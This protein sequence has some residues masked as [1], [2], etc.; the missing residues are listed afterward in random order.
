MTTLHVD[1][2]TMATARFAVSPLAETVAALSLL[3][4]RRLGPTAASWTARH[5]AAAEEVG[6]DEAGRAL[7]ELLARTSWFPDFLTPLALGRSATFAA[8]LAAV[9]RTP[10]EKARDDLATSLGGPMPA[11]LAAPDLVPRVTRILERVWTACVKSD[12]PRHRAVLERDIIHRAGLLVTAG[13]AQALTGLGPEVRWLGAGRIKVNA[14]EGAE[15]H[16]GRAQLIFVPC[17]LGAGWLGLRPPEAYVVVYPARGVGSPDGP[18]DGSGADALIGTSRARLLRS[19]D[20]PGTPSQL[21]ALHGLSLGTVG[22]HLSILLAAGT[23]TAARAG[24]SVWYSRTALGD[25]LLA[26]HV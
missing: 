13:W 2:Q 4:G 15:E 14:Y 3:A 22:E 17:A 23:V 7:L 26:G 20:T 12:W 11:S 8:E 16:V 24:R 25:A 10:P 6:R 21:A 19:L 5:R 9:A 18:S 1:S